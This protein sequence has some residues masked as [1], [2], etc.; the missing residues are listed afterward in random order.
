[1]KTCLTTVL[2]KPTL[3]DETS[4]CNAINIPY[5][6]A[7]HLPD[8]FISDCVIGLGKYVDLTFS[9]Y[10]RQSTSE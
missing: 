5:R 6:G 8:L 2:N 10:E 9:R 3:P 1:M 4:R 7:L